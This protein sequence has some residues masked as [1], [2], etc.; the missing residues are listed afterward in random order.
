MKSQ[1]QIPSFKKGRKGRG[2]LVDC[3]VMLLWKEDSGKW[4]AKT[5]DVLQQELSRIQRYTVAASTVRSAVYS[6][7]DLFERDT[8]DEGR[9]VWRLSKMARGGR[10]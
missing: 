3:I 8:T 4:P 2:S 5:F 6:A 9:L 7:A 10:P 1:N